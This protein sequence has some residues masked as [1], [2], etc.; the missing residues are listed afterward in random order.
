MEELLVYAILLDGG[1]VTENEYHKR[2]DELFLN[3]PENED[4]LCLEWETDIKKAIIYV[5]THTDYINLDP[6]R[7]GRILMGKLKVVY[8]NCSDIKWFASECTVCGK[9]FPGTFRAW[10]HFGPCAMLMNLCHGEMK[11]R[12]ET[13]MNICWVTMRIKVISVN[14]G[15][16]GRG[17]IENET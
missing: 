15:F 2:L 14:L 12:P 3:D 17:V 13:F 11:S 9:V 6:E 8:A 7:F 10:N 1:I 4:L 16:F 5:R